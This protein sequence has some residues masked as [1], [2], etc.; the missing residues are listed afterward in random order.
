[1]KILRHILVILVGKIYSQYLNGQTLLAK[2]ANFI[3]N[4]MLNT[5]NFEDVKT[6]KPKPPEETTIINGTYLKSFKAYLTKSGIH[7]Q[8]YS[9]LR[10]CSNPSTSNDL[11]EELT[12]GV[13][14]HEYTHHVLDKEVGW[15]ACKQFDNL[16]V[17]RTALDLPT[18]VVI[19]LPEGEL[20]H[21]V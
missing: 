5:V 4:K 13:L 20:T 7:V 9:R 8:L 18:K 21:E 17:S 1:M 16:K 15:R 19:K 11:V 12:P 2:P 10:I 14:G 3:L 6:I